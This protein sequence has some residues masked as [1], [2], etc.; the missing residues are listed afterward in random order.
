MRRCAAAAR[1]RCAAARHRARAGPA[2]ARPRRAA[3]SRRRRATALRA[4][5]AAPRCA[6][7]AGRPPAPMPQAVERRLGAV[8]GSAPLAACS[9]GA[10]PTNCRCSP[11]T[12]ASSRRATRRSSTSCA[13]LRDESRRRDRRAAGALCR[14]ETA[15]TSLKI[16]HNNVLGYYVE[17]TP[18]TA[19]SCCKPPL[20]RSSS[21]AR[22]MASAMRY[23]TVELAELEAR[24]ASAG[25]AGAGARAARC[26]TT[27]RGGRARDGD[28]DR[29][30]GRRRWPRSMSPPAWPSWRGDAGWVRPEVDDGAAL[31]DQRR[32][33]SG[34]RGGAARAGARPS[35]PTI[36]ICSATGGRLV[37]GDRPE[38]GRQDHVPAAERADR[39]PGADR[40]PSCRRAAAQI[41][42]VDRLFSRVGAADDL[43][44]GRSTFMVEM[45]ETAAI[46]N[47]AGPRALVILDEIGRGTATFDGLSIA[48]AAVE[49]LHE[50]NRCRALFATH[51]HELTALAA[52]LPRL[53]NATDAGQ[54]MAGR[55]G[56]PARGRAGRR[57]PLLRHPGGAAG[58]PAGRG[59]RRARG[60][61][62]AAR[63]R[64]RRRA[65]PRAW[66]TTC[67]CSRRHGEPQQPAAAAGPSA[68]ALEARLA[69]VRADELTPRQALELV[70][71]LKAILAQGSG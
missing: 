7:P 37:A 25:R 13:T 15:I 3:R 18:A 6:P 55:R 12:A 51:Y 2:G 58:R 50:V 40:A 49:H 70:Y 54:G 46:L 71:E 45:V 61:A 29:G 27:G 39:D 24:I 10:R 14:G 48:W 30:R 11:A 1:A 57:R 4:G 9:R 68:P 5:G 17:V 65:P 59:G 64:A 63:G 26:S 19:R 28:G 43:A 38:H 62:G 41:G 16:R 35:S 21:T 20:A 23:T 42:I 66:P 67:R 56:V 47:Q 36:A 52:R 32:A 60:G 22:R 33:P 34:G 8:A 31:R 53:A 44:R 69:A